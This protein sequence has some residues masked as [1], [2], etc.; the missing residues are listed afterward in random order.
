MND[1]AGYFSPYEELEDKNNEIKEGDLV[2]IT[3]GVHI[4]NF[5]VVLA[6]SIIAGKTDDAKK[7]SALSAAYKA[8]YAVS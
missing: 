4:D 3:I 5:P 6:H 2:K 1:V 7:E 8:L